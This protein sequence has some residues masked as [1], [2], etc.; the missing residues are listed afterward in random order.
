MTRAE[1]KPPLT[2]RRR[3]V[4][5]IRRQT[6][7]RWARWV[8]HGKPL[9]DTF[10]SALGRLHTDGWAVIPGENLWDTLKP[11]DAAV[12][13]FSARSDERVWRSREF[14]VGAILSRRDPVVQAGIEGPIKALADAFYGLHCR[15]LYPDVWVIRPVRAGD[16]RRGSQV[17]H[18]DPEDRPIL[19]AFYYP[20][21]VTED[22]GPT[23]YESPNGRV[24]LTCPPRSLV[25][26]DASRLHRGGYALGGIRRSATWAFVTPAS[27]YPST[28]SL[29]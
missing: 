2:P 15:L 11:V 20:D 12:R 17:W 25:L 24:A 3:A 29:V 10:R 16:D 5:A 18:R 4:M 1:Y 6:L 8:F 7:N 21:G 13:A 19:K 23:E 28:F 22:Q 14:A 9:P 26:F 27:I